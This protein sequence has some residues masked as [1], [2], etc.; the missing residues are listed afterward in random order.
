MNACDV[1][2][3]QRRRIFHDTAVADRYLKIFLVDSRAE[4]LRQ[5]ERLT[6]A[7]RNLDRSMRMGKHKM[8]TITTH[9]INGKFTESHGKEIFNLINPTN[10]TVIDCV[11]LGDEEDPR[12]HPRREASLHFKTYS[13]SSLGEH[14]RYLRQLHDAVG[15]GRMNIS[16]SGPRSMAILSR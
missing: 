16:R 15:R 13:N 5:H 11:P 14:R 6:R 1:A 8:K 2:M 3:M 9:C 4:H 7:D 12:R 10:K